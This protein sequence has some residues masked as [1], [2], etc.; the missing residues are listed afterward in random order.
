M[1]PMASIT[2]P[3]S[4][5]QKG[6]LRPL[7]VLHDLPQVADLIERC[8][9]FTMDDDGQS[10]LQQMRNASRD[11]D[12]LRWAG[13][14]MESTSMPLAGFVWEEG[15]KIIG[16]ASL[17][18]QSH[19]GRKLAMIANV[20]THP[21]HRRRGIGRALTERAMLSARQR[22]ASDLWLQVRDDNP[23]AIKIYEDL[24]FMERARRTT[25]RSKS[26]TPDPQERRGAVQ[27]SKSTPEVGGAITISHVHGRHWATQRQWL[28]RAHPDD[29]SWYARWDWDRLGP[30][31][32]NSLRRLFM[33]FD[34]RQWAATQEG[35]LLATVS[36]LPGLRVA[37]ALWVAAPANG[38]GTGLT[39]V[40]SAA[41]RELAYYRK[42][43]VE[44]PAGEMHEAIEAAGFEAFRTLLW[45]QAPAT[46]RRVTRIEPKKET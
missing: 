18:Y 42:L 7:N 44:Y 4:A 2:L 33:Q 11:R 15:G 36:W 5:V 24:G 22:G 43:T 16:N 21:D 12:F 31:L 26:G 20:A 29:L 40:L 34:T 41:R 27:A 3:A 13:R 46:T 28:E 10:Y 37:N 9:Q 6:A 38:D 19:R 23:T 1:D 14:V 35:R 8:F 30:G 39:L 45:M 17:V 32:R 25:F